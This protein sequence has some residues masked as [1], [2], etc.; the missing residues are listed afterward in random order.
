MIAGGGLVGLSAA[1]AFARALP[2]T[3]LT[4]I[5]TGPDP[6]ALADL[7]P[8]SSPGIEHFHAAIGLEERDL[9]RDGIATH[10]LGTIFEH[11]SSSGAAWI[12]AFGKYG[13]PADGVPFDQVWFYA[14]QAGEVGTYER[15][16]VGAMLARHGKFVHPTMDPNSL[17][18]GFAYGLRL[19]PDRYRD[20]LKQQATASGVA[21]IS[22]GVGRV[23]PKD[24]GVAALLLTDGRRVEADL[25]VD[26]TGPSARLLAAIDDSF[27]DWSAWIPFDRLAISSEPGVMI[28]SPAIRVRALNNGWSAE[29]TLR[30]RKLCAR[31]AIAGLGASIR[32]GRRLRPW[33]GNVLALGDAAT[34]FDPLH[35]FNL[36]AAQRAILLALE[37]LPGRDFNPLET[38]E[39]NRRSEQVTRR[40]R[41]FIILH[42]LRSGR[43]SGLWAQLGEIVPP[44]SLARTLEQYEYRG[45][46]P[47]HE[48]ESVTRYSWAA[49][50]IGMGI[51]PA[52]VDPQ[53]AGVP[54][55][56]AFSAMRQLAREIDEV[57]QRLP[58]YGDYLA[59]MIR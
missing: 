19:D 6:A 22:G 48:E 52:K 4:V 7:V 15:Y 16:S 8:L 23:E 32:P 47:F 42:Y 36:D 50:L 14:R 5:D 38:G 54:L 26:C 18:S 2:D 33:I 43:S 12:H 11:W 44:D 45:R 21:F 35:G 41:D 13:K 17:G 37:L 40:M 39:Y 49:A 3:R 59:R 29:W 55:D 28:A 53:A 46:L 34:A 27:E 9:V 20:R 10:H 56:R 1:T 51:V 24:G 58:N 31:L 30:G 57:V 25:F